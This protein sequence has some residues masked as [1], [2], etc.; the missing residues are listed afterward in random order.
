MAPSKNF[1]KLSTYIINPTPS[2]SFPTILDNRLKTLLILLLLP[3]LFG[4]LCET[5]S[6]GDV[7]ILLDPEA[8]L[9][10]LSFLINVEEIESTFPSNTSSPLTTDFK[11]YNFACHRFSNA[12]VRLS[13]A[14]IFISQFGILNLGDWI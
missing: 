3:V 13:N 1:V 8:R 14:A 7:I 9:S 11:S 6:T 2:S 10:S 5:A 12:W 4:R